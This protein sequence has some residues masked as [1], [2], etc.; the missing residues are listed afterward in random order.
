MF[1]LYLTM[2][3][4]CSAQE[5]PTFRSDV[6]LVRVDAEVTNGTKTLNG[7][8]KEDFIV[9]DK[10]Q[11]QQILYFS[12]EQV[13]LD[14]ILLFDISGS[15][16]PNVERVAASAHTA[17][18]ELHPGD[19][20]AIMTFHRSSRIVAPLS[21]DLAAVERTINDKVVDGRFG[22]GTRLLAGVDDAAK[23]F[24]EQPRNERRRAVVILT[25]NYGQRSRQGSTVVHRL[26]EADA[27][28]SGLI[29]RRPGD[30]VVNTVA[31]A[32]NPLILALREGME[33][34]AERTGGDTLKADNAGEDF[35]E[36]MRR[37]R[38]RYSLYYA[39]PQ[40]KPGEQR[41]VKVELSSEALSNYPK[42]R[43]RAPKG[44]VVH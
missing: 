18:A 5:A 19:R 17:L 39:M 11:P 42:A 28:L 33:G 36:M 8:R 41:M 20:V 40:G 7:F 35:R 26:W 12:R 25:D 14:V 9:K 4:I 43:V 22:G 23:Y 30:Q 44:Y 10:G 13:P 34:V 32:M 6:A 27:S 2:A 24:L 37:I 31:M 29:I 16:R 1:A 3:L 21:E 38:Q 15:M